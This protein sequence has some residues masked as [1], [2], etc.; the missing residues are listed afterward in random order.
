MDEAD[1]VE[2]GSEI[3]EKKVQNLIEGHQEAL[4]AVL[5]CVEISGRPTPST[6]MLSP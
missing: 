1:K 5:C 2:V 6:T 3:S 4:R